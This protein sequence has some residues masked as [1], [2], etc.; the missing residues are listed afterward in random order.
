MTTAAQ[1][2]HHG[3]SSCTLKQQ[4]IIS[5]LKRCA[6]TMAFASYRTMT[7]PNCI[8]LKEKSI[9][10]WWM[11]LR[12]HMARSWTSDF[13]RTILK[14]MLL[15]MCIMMTVILWESSICT[16]KWLIILIMTPVCLSY[17]SNLGLCK[18]RY[19]LIRCRR[20]RWIRVRQGRITVHLI[21]MRCL[22]I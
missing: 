12:S 11:S 20:C 18:W 13:Q 6:S 22:R 15:T 3:L 21:G 17:K 19:R 9:L 8:C 4:S 7:Q 5:N 14:F 2:H 10:N 1:T 16:F